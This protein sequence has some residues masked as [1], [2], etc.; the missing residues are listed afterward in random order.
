M[1]LLAQRHDLLGKSGHG[2]FGSLV[3]HFEFIFTGEGGDKF[4]EVS[5]LLEDFF[6]ERFVVGLRQGFELG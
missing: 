3:D 4:V 6:L 1:E 2:G 5:E